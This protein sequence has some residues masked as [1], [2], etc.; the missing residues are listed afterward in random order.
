MNIYDISQRSGVSIATVSRVINNSSKVS[1]S[2]RE[3][4]LS[5]MQECGYTPNAFARSLG[6]NSMYTVGILCVDSSDI[7]YSRVIYFLEQHLRQNNY[8]SMLSYTGTELADKKKQLQFLLS[9][10]VDALLLV[11]SGFV[12]SSKAAN[13]YLYEAAKK[14][15]VFL[16]NGCLSGSNIYSVLCDDYQGM[17]ELTRFLVQR[18]MRRPLYLHRELNYSGKSKLSGF[19]SACRKLLPD[20]TGDRVFSCPDQF[21]Q[22]VRFLQEHASQFPPFDAILA[23]DDELAAAAVKFLHA[24]GLSIPDDV[25]VTGYN[26]SSYALCS[27][28][29]I[30]SLDNRGAFLCSTAVSQILQVLQ[31]KDIPPSTLFTGTIIPRETT[32]TL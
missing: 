1:A 12:E 6:L 11:G 22:A 14:V 21:A 19:T 2:T 3:K 31:G 25:Q 15:P 24:Q 30:T 17:Y 32:R 23:S 20:L 8:A 16:L 4:V 5:V 27:T 18:G 7:F 29:E 10:Q 13:S 26:N 9:H 28:P